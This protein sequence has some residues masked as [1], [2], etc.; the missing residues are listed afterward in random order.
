VPPPVDE[1]DG[2]WDVEAPAPSIAPGASIKPVSAAPA[3][4]FSAKTQSSI[5]PAP[6]S[7]P[8]PTKP[9]SSVP[10]PPEAIRPEHRPSKGP[11]GTST[12]QRPTASHASGKPTSVI[13]AS[14]RP[15]AVANAVSEDFGQPVATSSISEAPASNV[16][17]AIERYSEKQLKAEATIPE[18]QG[19]EPSHAGAVSEAHNPQTATVPEPQSFPIAVD[20]RQP[21]AISEPQSLPI[22]IDVQEP[23]AASEPQSLPIA[24]DLQQAA[25]VSAVQSS[26]KSVDISTSLTSMSPVVS[27][28]S[29]ELS[30]K[31]KSK[32]KIWLFVAAAA[33][34][35]GGVWGAAGPKRATLRKMVMAV[36]ATHQPEKKKP[37]VE[38]PKPVDVPAINSTEVAPAVAEAAPP[39]T[40]EPERPAI[41]NADPSASG[42][43]PEPPPEA[44]DPNVTK[45]KVEV[46]PTDSTIALYG[47]L[48]KGPRVFDVKKGTRTIL[49]VAHP[50]YITR[51]IVLNGKK[52]FLRIMMTPLP[53][54][55][56]NNDGATTGAVAPAGAVAP[57]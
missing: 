41:A 1:N 19:E 37:A 55:K 56:G 30:V 10:I 16:T 33:L 57:N 6:I 50:G 28:N 21:V 18:A 40:N 13:P 4:D 3:A 51:R 26:Q 31:P 32:S 5:P 35:V 53:K 36:T 49:E 47:K 8:A 24:A 12:S 9:I 38:A 44:T 52:P 46:V 7:D 17:S 25:A 22:A 42:E 27:A 43:T 23:A 2:D 45:V 20:I 15:P 11:S 39:A 29:E 14:S 48:V 54:S 34:L